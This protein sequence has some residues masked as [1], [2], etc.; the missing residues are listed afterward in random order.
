MYIL[1]LSGNQW[2]SSSPA[3]RSNR[4][5]PIGVGA[6]NIVA[7]GFGVRISESYD[8]SI[9]RVR[10]Q[11][12][13]EEESHRVSVLPQEGAYLDQLGW[14]GSCIVLLSIRCVRTEWRML[15]EGDGVAVALR[16]G[17]DANLRRIRRRRGRRRHESGGW[18]SELCR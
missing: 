12:G 6:G 8:S 16:E 9:E 2:S 18:F 17:H 11:L 1:S 15:R 4:C 5:E 13:R 7:R 14:A 3:G 10:V